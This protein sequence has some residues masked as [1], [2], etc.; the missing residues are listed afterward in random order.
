MKKS[1]CGFLIVFT[2][3]AFSPA[4]AGWKVMPASSPVSVAK[5]KLSVVAGPGWNMSSSRP[6]KKAEIWSFDGPLL[7][8]I[9]FITAISDG[10]PLAREYNKKRQPLPKFNSTMLQTDIVQLF[11]QTQR[12]T[13]NT[14]DFTVDAIE[15]S[16]FAGQNGF[17]F[18]YHYTLPDEELTRKGEARGVV[19]EKKLYLM[20]FTAAAVHYFDRD[21]VKVRAIMDSARL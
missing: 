5:S 2:L 16:S 8:Q 17:V 15:P 13:L 3:I 7:N 12:I 4:N 19:V 18:R 6:F 21:I 10:E 20:A 11:E 14:A 9:E 1:T